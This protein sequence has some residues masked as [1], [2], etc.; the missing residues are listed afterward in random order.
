M[1]NIKVDCIS[2]GFALTFNLKSLDTS[3]HALPFMKDQIIGEKN[4]IMGLQSCLFL[5]TTA[6]SSI[7]NKMSRNRRISL[8]KI[9]VADF[10]SD[11][12]V[13][14]NLILMYY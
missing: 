14:L 13:R 2:I 3:S 5:I 8:R 12:F 10:T 11:F 1:I 4:G 7:K 9:T 6:E